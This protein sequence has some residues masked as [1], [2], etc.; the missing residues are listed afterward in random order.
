MYLMTF[1]IIDSR[2]NSVQLSEAINEEVMAN[3]CNLF[4]IKSN[5]IE[6]AGGDQLRIMNGD[7]TQVLELI[8]YTLVLLDIHK[9]KA[10]IFISVG[11]YEKK[12]KPIN[13][14]AGDIFY[15]NKELE[16][17]VKSQKLSKAN[18]VYYS[19]Y[20]KTLEIDLLVQ[21]FAKLVLSKPAYLGPLYLYAFKGLTQTQIADNLMM[22]QST[23]NNQL[24]KVNKDLLASYN[25]VISNLIEEE[26]CSHT[27]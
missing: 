18:S 22:S 9:L 21:S 20:E 1:D 27:S 5:L 16:G 3:Y 6:I 2:T 12:D 23:I 13:M 11:S 26:I 7:C 15:K 25:T 24:N 4:N 14:L 19:G 17:F 10:R 8:V